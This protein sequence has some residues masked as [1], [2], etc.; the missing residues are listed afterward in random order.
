MIG[1]EGGFEENEIEEAQRF[2]FNKV[3]IFPY[4]LRTELAVVTAL[5]GIRTLTLKNSEA[6]NGN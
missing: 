6:Y 2:G 5:A 1:P 3:N 4:R